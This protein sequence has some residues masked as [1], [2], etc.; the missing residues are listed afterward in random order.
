MLLKQ[1]KNIIEKKIGDSLVVINEKTKK[2]LEIN[3]TGGFIWRLI[4]KGVKKTEIINKIAE[5]Y[6]I[7]KSKAGK[8]VDEYIKK[9][10]RFKLIEEK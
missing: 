2:I 5:K 3:K 10:R 7:E 8:D 4:K 1:N 9:L 6:R